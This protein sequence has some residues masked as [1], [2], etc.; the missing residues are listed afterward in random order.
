MFTPQVQN[1][2]ENAKKQYSTSFARSNGR[3]LCYI[4]VPYCV[5]SFSVYH[6]RRT[7]CL[8]NKN[9]CVCLSPLVS[10]RSWFDF[11]S[12]SSKMTKVSLF[13]YQSILITFINYLSKISF[14]LESIFW[15]IN[16]WKNCWKKWLKM[17]K[18]FNNVPNFCTKGH[19]QVFIF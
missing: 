5:S 12:F 18:T 10:S 13:Y 15:R 17:I 3:R 2:L 14:P 16:L 8:K 9:F 4:I 19:K 11:R 6:P 7:I 1:L